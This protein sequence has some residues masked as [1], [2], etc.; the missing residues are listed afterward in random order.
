MQQRRIWLGTFPTAEMAARAYDV[1]ALALRGHSA[2]LNFADSVWRLPVPVSKDAVDIRKAAN[3]AAESFRRHQKLEES[4]TT[5]SSAC[6]AP[7]RESSN[8]TCDNVK[9]ERYY[10][11][12]STECITSDSVIRG[13][14]DEVYC[15][16][17]MQEEMNSFVDYEELFDMP[18][19][20]ANMAEGLLISPPL[21]LQE[22]ESE[23]DMSL[24][25]FSF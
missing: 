16:N 13:D 17:E 7:K 22:M 6:N 14:D 5:A 23:V 25:N 3:E 19:L 2:C 20:M 10:E 24:W 9:T 15:A 21:L 18:G 8:T 1:A 11:S 12:S 4:D